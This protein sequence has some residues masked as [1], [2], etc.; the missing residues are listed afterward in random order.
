MF[1]TKSAGSD[2]Y[3][4]W[5]QLLLAVMLSWPMKKDLEVAEAAAVGITRAIHPVDSVH[6]GHEVS[7]RSLRSLY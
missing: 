3:N 1:I 5:E 6:L 4:G 7:V 2:N